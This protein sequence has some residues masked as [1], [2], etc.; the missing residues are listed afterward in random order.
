MTGMRPSAALVLA[1]LAL[2]DAVRPS[3]SGFRDSSSSSLLAAPSAVGASLSASPV[4]PASVDPCYDREGERPVSCV[5][6]FVNAAFGVRVQTEARCDPDAAAGSG[7]GGEDTCAAAD[8]ARHDVGAHFLTDLHNPL[9]ESCWTTEVS[10]T[11]LSINAVQYA[12]KEP[13][14]L[15]PRWPRRRPRNLGR[16]NRRLLGGSVE[17]NSL[18]LNLHK[19]DAAVLASVLAWLSRDTTCASSAVARGS[20][21]PPLVGRGAALCLQRW[22]VSERRR[23]RDHAGPRRQSA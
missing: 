23:E 20:A 11:R 7:S 14:S 21:K 6:D 18:P 17:A 3:T 10:E 13:L 22:L 4:A 1:A 12:A 2:T 15:R 16:F 19:D 5:P 9:N 8:P